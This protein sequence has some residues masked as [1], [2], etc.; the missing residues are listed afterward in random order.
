MFCNN[1]GAEISPEQKFCNYCG[2][3]LNPAIR[4]QHMAQQAQA[5]QA[6]ANQA[7]MPGYQIP[8]YQPVK[9]AQPGKKVPTWLI[10]VLIVAALLLLSIGSVLGVRALIS[11]YL[12]KA[13]NSIKPSL[14]GDVIL[15][16]EE[17]IDNDLDF[18]F[19]IDLGEDSDFDLE[20]FMGE[21]LGEYLLDDEN[22]VFQDYE[23]AT[24]MMM[25]DFA[26]IETNYTVDDYTEL[27]PGKSLGGLCD[28]IDSEVLEDGR[29]IDRKLLYDLV[30]VHLIDSKLIKKDEDLENNLMYCL[31]FAN[32]FS[33][34][35]LRITNCMYDKGEP[36]IYYYDVKIGNEYDTWIVD[37]AEGTV[38]MNYGDTD[39]ESAGQ[40]G[41]FSS[42]T[43]AIWMTVVDI[44]YGIG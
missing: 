44:Y 42:D 22:Y 7:G 33:G 15:G 38:S 34:Q 13:Q 18:D 24:A 26:Y 36:D 17:E 16:D 9:N 27:R 20:D 41:M 3:A 4:Y 5:N 21:E 32:E 43:L 1:C 31:S 28:Y 6:Q 11:R 35:N 19:D 29:K 30:S 10:V 2:V 14:I 25:D 12:A 23:Y 39:Y 8:G 37:C 40:Y